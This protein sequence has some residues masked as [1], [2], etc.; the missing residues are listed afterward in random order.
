L[1]N[2]QEE[3]RVTADQ[4]P[5]TTP[6]RRADEVLTLMVGMFSTGAT[7]N[8]EAIVATD[9]L[10]HQGLGAGPVRGPSGFRTVVTAA[11]SGYAV[12]DVTIEDLIAQDD[13]C[14][15]RL[16]WRGTRLSGEGVERETLEFVR[17]RNG[18]AV[19]HWG[20]RS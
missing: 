19:E 3:P 16:R 12:L 5:Q 17:V 11:R 4:P 18:L 15:A 1:S 8:V 10:D 13:R 2:N 20:G 14:A 7:D 9:Y 6:P